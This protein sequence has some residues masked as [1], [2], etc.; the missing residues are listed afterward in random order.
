[1]CDDIEATVDQLRAKQA[2]FPVPIEEREYGRVIMMIMP[3]ADDTALPAD[4]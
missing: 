1:M 3:D 4:A 2:Q